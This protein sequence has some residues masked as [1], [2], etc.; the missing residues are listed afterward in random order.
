MVLVNTAAANRDPAVYDDPDRVDITREGAPPILTF[1]GGVHYCLGA[2]LARREIAEALNVIASRLLNPRTAGP[3][4]WKPMVE[5]E[6]PE[7]PADRVRP[8]ALRRA[9]GTSG[10]QT[11]TRTLS[12]A[13]ARF[14]VCSPAASGDPVT[15]CDEDRVTQVAVV[16]GPLY[17]RWLHE[18]NGGLLMRAFTGQTVPK[19]G[20]ALVASVACAG[21]RV[22]FGNRVPARGGTNHL[23]F[24]EESRHQRRCVTG[25]DN[26]SVGEG[27]E[28]LWRNGVLRL[29]RE[30][31]GQQIRTRGHPAQDFRSE[32][33]AI[34]RAGRS[35][36]RRR[37]DSHRRHLR[38]DGH[39]GRHES[40]LHR[41]D[42]Q[43]RASATT[44][45]HQGDR[46]RLR[47]QGGP[48]VG[49]KRAATADTGPE[50]DRGEGLGAGL[51]RVGRG[52]DQRVHRRARTHV[53][54]PDRDPFRR[55]LVDAV[56]R[57]AGRAR[58][59]GRPCVP[60]QHRPRPRPRGRSCADPAERQSI[61][62]TTFGVWTPNYPMAQTNW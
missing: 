30:T 42:R 22:L 32:D 11:Q 27:L 28:N 58:L 26:G 17:A 4:P 7:E 55:R 34:R 21:R 13:A 62:T 51:H 25:T 3:V 57:P 2:N 50:D 43:T 14:C 12:S 60:T 49:D 40:R 8:I 24:F 33:R 29:P 5:P 46:L 20:L 15:G 31:F 19:F 1:G 38:A 45:S 56:E 61:R 52:L 36:G 16:P 37:R 41:D 59:A 23:D 6:R 9:G 35:D 18:L 48:A 10:E 44:R 39:G 53:A 54:T 47:L